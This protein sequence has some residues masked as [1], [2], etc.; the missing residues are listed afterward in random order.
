MAFT[1][2]TDATNNIASLANKPVEAPA[3]LKQKFDQIGEDLK[4]Y[5]NNTLTEELEATT[6]AANLG[7]DLGGGYGATVQSALDTIV[8]AGSGTIPPDGTISNSKL[9][10]DVKVGSLATLTTT[11]KGS[12]VGAL[13]EID[14][15]V[16]LKANKVQEDFIEPTLLNGWVNYNVTT[17]STAKYFKDDFGIVHLSGMIKDGTTA[18]G[19]DL[20][21]LPVGYR[22]AKTTYFPVAS[23]GAFG[24]VRVALTGEVEI[25][26]GSATW[27]SLDGISFKAV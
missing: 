6:A 8:A 22:I 14:A 1:K 19:T 24:S 3:T 10:T 21:I 7:Q 27:L 25:Q 26:V 23:N 11:E 20:F 15:N 12:V 5:I 4:D 16:D 17:F 9:A 13:N 2:V 18:S